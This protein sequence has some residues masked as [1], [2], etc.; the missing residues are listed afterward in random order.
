[1]MQEAGT[2]TAKAKEILEQEYD[3]FLHQQGQFGRINMY[4]TY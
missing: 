1:M 2:I 3:K 4:K